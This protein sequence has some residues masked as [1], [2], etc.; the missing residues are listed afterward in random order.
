VR[1]GPLRRTGAKPVGGR[2]ARVAVHE[3]INP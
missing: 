2:S 3:A 1:A